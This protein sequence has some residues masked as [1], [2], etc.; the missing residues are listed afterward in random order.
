VKYGENL[1]YNCAAQ[2]NGPFKGVV[3][4]HVF[5]NIFINDIKYLDSEEAHFSVINIIRIP[6][7]LFPDDLAIEC[8]QFTGYKRKLH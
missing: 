8:S 6:R 4:V 5:I 7:L 3:L 1:I 2:T